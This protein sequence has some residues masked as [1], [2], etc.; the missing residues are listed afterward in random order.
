M[1][2]YELEI[3]K[4]RCES[5]LV[6][7]D[8]QYLGQLSSNRYQSDSITNEYGI[9]GSKYSST[10]IYNK[11]GQYGSPYAPFSAFNPYTNTPPII[12][13]RG[14]KI[15]V[16]TTNDYLINSIDSCRLYEWLLEHCL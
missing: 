9:Y 10:S 15:G 16:L 5:F 4:K 6:A 13:L 2:K 12:Y 1:T 3:R 8:G 7:A 14:V 11:Y